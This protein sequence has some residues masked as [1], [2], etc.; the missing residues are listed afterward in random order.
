MTYTPD[1]VA[2]TQRL[3]ELIVGAHGDG[4]GAEAAS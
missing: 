2:T 1:F 3:R 4:G